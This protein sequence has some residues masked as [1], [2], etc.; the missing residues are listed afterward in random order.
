MTDTSFPVL[1]VS[2][3]VQWHEAYD[4]AYA[5]DRDIVGGVTAKG[6]VGSAGGWIGGGGH[7]VLAPTFGLGLLPS[8]VDHIVVLAHSPY[9]QAL[10]M[11]SNSRLSPLLGSTL[12]LTRISIAISSGLYAEAEAV[13]TAL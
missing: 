10:T 8:S 3:G 2:A 5:Q 4:A 11:P 12:P 6:S 7:S 9:L 13:L 1:T